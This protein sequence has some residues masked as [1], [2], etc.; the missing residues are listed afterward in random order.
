M[1]LYRYTSEPFSL[2]DGEGSISELA[3]PFVEL[4]KYLVIRETRCFYYIKIPYK[5]KHKRVSKDGKSIFAYSTKEKAMLNYK[6][7]CASNLGHCA[8]AH[9]IARIFYKNSLKLTVDD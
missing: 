9:K 8:R 3:K 7:R 5:S 6:K 4:N 1:Y 2:Y